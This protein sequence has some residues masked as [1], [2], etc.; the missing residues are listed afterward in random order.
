[1]QTASQTHSGAGWSRVLG[2]FVAASVLLAGNI[3]NA[4]IEKEAAFTESE[5]GILHSS[6]CSCDGHNCCSVGMNDCLGH[7]TKKVA[8]TSVRS[9]VY[10]GVIEY[11]FDS[12]DILYGT[13]SLSAPAADGT[14][15]MAV[16][17]SGGTGK[18]AY[19]FGT[20]SGQMKGTPT[21]GGVQT[22]TST[23]SGVIYWWDNRVPEW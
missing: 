1:M 6:S 9:N 21:K 20:A 15:T 16:Q 19:T 3:T 10:T 23:L 22:Y 13:V 11:A 2:G 4:A 18:L 7:Y 12:G 17:F 14:R 5:A 8:W